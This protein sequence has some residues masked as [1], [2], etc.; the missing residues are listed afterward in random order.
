[1]D[2]KLRKGKK[3]VATVVACSIAI[4]ADGQEPTHL[5]GMV[6]FLVDYM[7]VRNAVGQRWVCCMSAQAGL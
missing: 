7:Y 1:M 4:D 3:S 5:A 2:A 6:K